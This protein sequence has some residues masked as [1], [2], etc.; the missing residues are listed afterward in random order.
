M[1]EINHLLICEGIKN[2]RRILVMYKFLS[3][4][5]GIISLQFLAMTPIAKASDSLPSG[6]YV[7]WT[8]LGGSSPY[9]VG[10]FGTFVLDGNGAYTNRAFKTSGRY[11]YDGSTVTFSGGKF[12]GYTAQVK[13]TGNSV[14]LKF[15]IEPRGNSTRSSTS[16][17]CSLSTK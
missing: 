12:D 1:K 17:S 2:T 8:F 7:C 13:K 6:K 3:L 5:I 16:Q 11:A 4:A 15:K 9:G 14:A 10:A